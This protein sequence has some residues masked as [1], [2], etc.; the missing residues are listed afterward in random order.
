MR[1]KSSKDSAIMRYTSSAYNY[2]YNA[3]GDEYPR[4]SVFEELE[5]VRHR[6][7]R[8]EEKYKRAKETANRM[9]EAVNWAVKGA[10]LVQVK[11]NGGFSMMIMG[12]WCRANLKGEFKLIEREP[13][14]SAVGAFMDPE[15]A[16]KFM[17][18]YG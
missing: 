17:L 6:A 12:N 1:V 18:F 2:D 13:D 15:D 8:L 4:P 14:R 11:H 5:K 16:I 3:D 7:E 10:K 9:A